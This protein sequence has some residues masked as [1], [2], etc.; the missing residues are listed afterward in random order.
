MVRF[1]IVKLTFQS[2]LHI[3]RGLGEA[4]DTAEKT[5]HSDTISGA[6][7]S[8]FCL[9]HPREDPL[10][11]M[12]TFKVSSAFPFIEDHFFLPR[13]LTRMDL[14]LSGNEKYEHKKILKKVEYV[15]V[16][17]W[18][19]LVSGDKIEVPSENL[20][21]G[22]KFLYADK[23]SGKEPYKD[24]LQ[25]RV[26]VPRDGGN[27]T[28]YFIERRYFNENAGLFFLL[29]T[30]DEHLEKIK[31]V[32][33]HLKDVGFGTDKS[34]GN[35][36]FS[37]GISEIEIA[38]SEGFPK[39]MLISLACPEKHEISTEMLRKSSCLLS[40]RGGFIAGTS[41]DQF[42]H[43]RKRS[44]YMFLEGSVF[45]MGDFLGKIEN[46][47]PTW[48]DELLHN[49]YRDGRAFFLPVNI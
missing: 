26:T 29:D 9:L 44:V 34:V 36:Q 8:T 31:D 10:T 45:P 48:N 25:Q 30:N 33:E 43:L 16:S 41:M 19:L 13:P 28:P 1:K 2:P 17:L 5:M 40:R 39:R 24:A 12:K 23:V 49:V 3:G 38:V 15:E 27:A 47:R 46:V 6:L 14:S 21:S 22:G 37:F 42:R 18:S 7:A 35:G 4:Y 32:L 11:F 20:S